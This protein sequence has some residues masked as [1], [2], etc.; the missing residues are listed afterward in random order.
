M[1]NLERLRKAVLDLNARGISNYQ[2]AQATGLSEATFYKIKQRKIERPQKTTVDAIMNFVNEHKYP[3]R[4]LKE[5]DASQYAKPEKIGNNEFI[6][7]SSV[8]VMFVPLVE[9]DDKAEF[10]THFDDQFFKSGLRKHA[11]L[12][13]KIPKG[14]HIAFRITD[15]SMDDG[16]SESYREGDIVTGREITRE[17]WGSRFH[18]TT[19]KDYVIVHKEGVLIR[20]ITE[21]LPEKENIICKSR[22]ADKAQFPDVE[23]SFNDVNMILSIV[24]LYRDI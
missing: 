23:I 22:N 4:K 20:T 18:I 24:N 13:D 11:L 21:H 3:K 10:L 14:F 17:L 1:S 5:L 8:N 7:T 16:S 6:F 12:V 9:E 15:G 2:I 19:Q